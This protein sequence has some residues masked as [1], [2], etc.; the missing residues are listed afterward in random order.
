[1]GT[2]NYQPLANIEH[3][4]MVEVVFRYS[5]LPLAFAQVVVKLPTGADGCCLNGAELDKHILAAAPGRDWFE[6]QEARLSGAS[7]VIQTLPAAFRAVAP[8]SPP[9]REAKWFETVV[10]NEPVLQG[11]RW[12][13]PANIIDLRAP[14]NLQMLKSRLRDEVARV[15][16]ERETGGVNVGGALILTDRESKAT[17]TGAHS[18]ALADPETTVQWKAKNGFVRLGAAEI[19][20]FGTA[21]FNHVQSCFAREH[22]INDQIDLAGSVSALMAIDIQSGWGS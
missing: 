22:A 12:V 2:L 5:D 17:I 19:M 11:G 9:E 15:R 20:Q 7:K 16:Y 21:V 10:V 6:A 4:E 1:M 14:Q 13:R 3:M 8:V 18:R